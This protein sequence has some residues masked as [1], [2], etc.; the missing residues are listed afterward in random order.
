MTQHERPAVRPANP[1]F[2]TGPCAKPPG[3]NLD[4]LRGAEV[5]RAHRSSAGRAKLRQVID[6]TRRVLC[7]PNGHRIAIVPGSDT[8]AVEMAMWT[9]LGQRMVEVLSWESFGKDWARDVTAQLRLP[10]KIHDTD[11]GKLPDLTKVDFSA[12]VVFAWNGTTSGVRVPNGDFIPAD[13][14]GLTIC[15]ATSAV[16]AVELPWAKLDAVTFSWQKVL[17]GEGAHGMLVLS[18]RAVERLQT[19]RPPWPVP[20]L[21]RL[22]SGDKVNEGIFSGATIN[23]PSLLCVED[24]IASLAWA[25]SVGGLPAL[26]ARAEKN[27]AVISRFV[28]RTAWLE[29]LA[30][31]PETRSITSVCLAFSDPD[32]PQNGMRAFSGNVVRRLEEEGAALDIGSYRSAPPGLR[33][34]CGS[35]VEASDLER[36]CAWIEWAFLSEKAALGAGQTEI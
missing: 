14:G 29:Y 10:A 21:F 32:I 27:A 36:L 18:P 28:D 35:T 12:D 33:I 13:R 1:R 17:G 4:L 11:Y 34:W 6:M 5:G 30:E 23:T 8:G 25:E 20:K 2:S 9:L 19:W 7:V 31:A 22:T 24:C 15:D 16:F 3:W 26:I